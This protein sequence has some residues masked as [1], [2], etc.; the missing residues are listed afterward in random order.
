MRGCK[1]WRNFLELRLGEVQLRGIPLP[2]TPLNKGKKKDR[3]SFTPSALPRMTDALLT[4]TLQAEALP[5]VHGAYRT[6]TSS[7]PPYWRASARSCS[8]SAS[9]GGPSGA[10]GSV[11]SPAGTLVA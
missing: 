2:R 8:I 10:G 1:T 7:S 11:R 4:T 3:G 5:L 6:Y 9:L